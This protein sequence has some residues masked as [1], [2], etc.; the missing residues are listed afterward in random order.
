MK[1]RKMIILVIMV[2]C[3]VTSIS[4]HKNYEGK[5]IEEIKEKTNKN[6]KLV[7]WIEQDDG[8]YKEDTN[9]AFPV[10]DYLINNDRTNCTSLEDKQIKPTI[11]YQNG[12]V[13]ISGKNTAYCEI[14]FDKCKGP[15]GTQLQDK[16]QVSKCEVGGMYRY[17][18]TDG[19]K[20]WI[21]FGTT[22]QKTCTNN[23]DKY[24]YRIIGVTPEG[25]LKLIKETAVKEN[26]V[27]SFQW[28]DKYETKDCGSNGEKCTWPDSMIYKRLN[29][30]SN[31][32]TSGTSGD[33]N[34][35]IGNSYYEYLTNGSVWL[36]K[37]EN[38]NWKYGD[39]TRSSYN[40]NELYEIENAFTTSDT[41]LETSPKAKI[42][43]MY[44]HDYL[45]AYKTNSNDAGNPGS[46]TNAKKAWIFFQ[47]DG[48]ND[49][50]S[51]DRGE[52]LLSRGNKMYDSYFP[53]YAITSN[54][55]FSS[56][57]GLN[58]FVIVRPV[59]YVT[60][61]TTIKSGTGEKTN[62]YILDVVDDQPAPTCTLIVDSSGVVLNK[63]ENS[64][65][66]GIVKDSKTPDYNSQT[67]VNE[68]ST[69]TYYGYVMNSS[70]I[71]GTCQLEMYQAYVHACEQTNSYIEGGIE[72]CNITTASCEC[73]YGNKRWSY[74]SGTYSDTCPPIGTDPQIDCPP[75]Y[76]RSC[77]SYV[78][79]C[80]CGI[81]GGS[82]V[83]ECSNGKTCGSPG[84][85]TSLPCSV[86]SCPSGY[87][88][89]TIEDITKVF[90]Y[91]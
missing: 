11:T 2:I 76:L 54:G 36:D 25:Q 88:T 35:F 77:G 87:T 31:G 40:G 86:D 85:C 38:Y 47:K 43:L 44:I 63:S 74:S 22:D 64:T 73:D 1:N 33:T 13:T 6:N 12:T 34:I 60:K 82:T 9:G 49:I 80:E 62:P 72:R 21:C 32:L 58:D 53:V 83:Y 37:I 29:G 48:Y 68:L 39:I 41:I 46:Y 78:Y 8:N 84:C 26:N 61:D 81:Y 89:L 18:G 71:T 75:E 27:M 50:T 14:Y 56:N 70:G 67:R 59:F 65:S 10:G 17:Q 7:F 55:S 20:N 79:A 42:G 52:G 23:V 19:V 3:I 24:M 66:Y 69:G 57:T 90:C 15:V 16:D 28:N 91:K 51:N 5:N 30:I 4:T 45:Y